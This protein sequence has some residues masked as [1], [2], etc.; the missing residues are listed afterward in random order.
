MHGPVEPSPRPAT[1]R[2]HAHDSMHRVLTWRSDVLKAFRWSRSGRTKS[3]PGWYSTSPPSRWPQSTR[4]AGCSGRGHAP[5]LTWDYSGGMQMLHRF[6]MAAIA[7]APDAAHL[8]EGVRFPI[9]RPGQLAACFRAAGLDDVQETPITI[10]TSFASVDDYWVPFLGGQGPAPSYVATLAP[11]AITRLR[12]V[13]R[14]AFPSAPRDPST[15]PRPLWS[16]RGAL[17]LSR[18]C[19]H[20]RGRAESRWQPA[21]PAPPAPSAA[22]RPGRRCLLSGS[23]RAPG[24]CRADPRASR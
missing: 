13:W 7:E 21:R 20:G 10:P 12:T 23:S 9:C 24:H 22:G 14:R 19:P 17:G 16:P 2:K 8:D 4:C 15:S 6:W 3:P 18:S 5:R 11:D 1:R